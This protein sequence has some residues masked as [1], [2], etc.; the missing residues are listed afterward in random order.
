MICSW[1]CLLERVVRSWCF[2]KY[3]L[4]ISAVSAFS[5]YVP[6]SCCLT[7]IIDIVLP[8]R[9]FGYVWFV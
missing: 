4:S 8:E 6:L 9:L 5:L 3:F 1:L 2:A 7:P